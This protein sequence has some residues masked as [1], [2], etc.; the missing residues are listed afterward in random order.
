MLQQPIPAKPA[1]DAAANVGAKRRPRS[2]KQH[3][4]GKAL[5]ETKKP[6]DTAT[7]RG[8]AMDVEQHDSAAAAV[9]LDAA[10]PGGG[11]SKHPDSSDAATLAAFLV[12]LLAELLEVWQKKPPTDV[13]SVVGSIGKL[14]T[15]AERLA[16]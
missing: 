4:A 7:E 10:T 11:L 12:G 14:L 2:K 6:A 3:K 9:Q 15:V 8:P 5:E 1:S 13:K 16:G